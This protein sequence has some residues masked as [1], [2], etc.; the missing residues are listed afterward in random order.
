MKTVK[1]AAILIGGEGTRLGAAVSDTPKPLLEVCGRPFVEHVM[2]NLRRFGFNEF[3]LLAGYRGDAV[4]VRYREHSAFAR[5]L[6]A[7]LHVVVEPKPLGTAGALRHAAPLLQPKFLLLNGD[8]FFDINYLDLCMCDA[9]DEPP[10]W[11]ARIAL[12]AAA[13]T[14]GYDGVE[15]CGGSISTIREQPGAICSGMVNGGVY[16]LDRRLLDWIPAAPASLEVDVL[17]QLAAAGRLAGRGYPGF[18]IDIGTPADLARARQVLGQVLRRPAAFLDRD[19]TL[20]RDTGYTH[21]IEDFHWLAGAREAIR[22]LNDAG[23]LVFI[24]TNQAGIARGYYDNAA[25]DTLHDW[26]QDDLARV[27]A[28]FD[29]LR[30]CPHHPEGCVPA[31]ALTCDCRKPATGM[32]DS[33]IGAWRPLLE[34][35]FMLGDADRDV[36]AGHGAGIASRKVAPGQLLPEVERFLAAAPKAT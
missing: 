12:R 4:R 36:A 6:D 32:L 26:M 16:W 35:S 11:L 2:L 21:R 22:K 24:V 1:Q 7:V 19:G 13:A 15:L 5:E 3:I 9:G 25:V 10:D 17:P 20:N 33:L 28:H 29:D 30:Y 18:F 34:S 27:G 31:L 8:T 14:A 23:Y